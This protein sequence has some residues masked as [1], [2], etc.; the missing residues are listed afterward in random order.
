MAE[1]ER[2]ALTDLDI[3]VLRGARD[4]KRLWQAEDVDGQGES[5]LKAFGRDTRVNRQVGKL[6]SGS[7]PLLYLGDPDG[8]RRRPWLLTEA[9]KAE[10]AKHDG[11]K[12]TA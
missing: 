3:E 10:L 11:P 6:T 4:D 5:F 7:E 12:G 2:A 9:G 1:K 8:F